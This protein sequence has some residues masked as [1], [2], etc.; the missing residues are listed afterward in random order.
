VGRSFLR[1]SSMWGRMRDDLGLDG[2]RSTTYHTIRQLPLNL[3][4][5]S[6]QIKWRTPTSFSVSRTLEIPVFNAQVTVRWPAEGYLSAGQTETGYAG[7]DV[8]FGDHVA[9]P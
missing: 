6:K 1:R 5:T 4:Y 9:N 8:R 3:S 7:C 2:L